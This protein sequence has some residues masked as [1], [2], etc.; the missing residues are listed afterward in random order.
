MTA[1]EK[2]T[3]SEV[4][5]IQKM[6]NNVGDFLD[7]HP[8][9]YKVVLIGCHFFRT[10]TMF[11]AMVYMPL[12]MVATAAIMVGGSLIYRAAVERFCCFRFTMESLM[13][14]GAAWLAMIGTINFISGAALASVGLIIANSIALLPVLGYTAWVIY[15]SHTDIENKMKTIGADTSN[16]EIISLDTCPCNGS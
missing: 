14:A 5:F 11:G 9:V 12:P 7:K 4:N 16:K 13:G 3:Q 2:T 1:I 6:Y 8:T 10:L 15:L